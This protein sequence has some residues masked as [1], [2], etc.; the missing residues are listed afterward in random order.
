MLELILIFLLVLLYVALCDREAVRLNLTI[1]GCDMAKKIGETVNGLIAPK[2]AAGNP[3]P[4]FEVL[5][6]DPGDAYD[7]T[8]APDG[9]TAVFVAKAAGTAN[10][11]TVHAISKSGAPLTQTKPLPDVEAAAPDEEVVDL[12]LEI[13]E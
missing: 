13:V 1:E 4:V 7:V 2:T 9:L 3:G 8:Q 10:F 5:W 6:V 11:A 12:G